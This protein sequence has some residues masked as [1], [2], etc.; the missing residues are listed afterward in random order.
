MFTGEKDQTL[1][2]PHSPAP[3]GVYQLQQ[4]YLEGRDNTG[5]RTWVFMDLDT[6]NLDDYW[7]SILNSTYIPAEISVEIFPEG[8]QRKVIRRKIT[9]THLGVF[10]TN[11]LLTSEQDPATTDIAALIAELGIPADSH[12]AVRFI[13]SLPVIISHKNHQSAY[14]SGII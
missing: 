12:F 11:C 6:N 4:R 13:S 1:D 9:E 10:R 7:F 5:A 3:N 14:H 8:L 2:L